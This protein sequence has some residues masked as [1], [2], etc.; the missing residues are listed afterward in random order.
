M[1]NFPF[2]QNRNLRIAGMLVLV[3]VVALADW[4]VHAEVPL[5]LLYLLPVA[6][7]GA[8]LS[9]PPI[10]VLALVCTALAEWFDGFIWIPQTALPRDVV[11]FCA[12]AGIGLFVHEV[13]TNRRRGVLHLAV[14][15][16]EIGARREV[17]EQFDILIGSSPIAILTADA[18]GHVLLA[19]DA[20]DRLFGVPSRCL[21]GQRIDAY[22]PAL[23]KV[24]AFRDGQP[25]FRTVMQCPG[26]RLDGEVFIAEVW[27]STYLTSVGA[28]LAAM[29]VDT[30][31]D[32][33]DREEANLH[34]L[35]TGSRILVSAVSHEVR[36]V[37][38]AIGVVHQNLAR[39]AALHGNKDFD[40]LGTL[41]LALE[42][43][44][45]IDLRDAVQRPTPLDLHSFFDE[46]QVIVGPTLRELGIE[47]SW[48][49]EGSLP[50]VW[51]DRQSLM[52]V[53]LNL[54]RNSQAA[55]LGQPQRRL[56]I[57]A[58]AAGN[59][60]VRI[61]L[62]D[63]G[64]GIAHP[65]LLFRPFQQRSHHVGLGLYLSR[66][67]MRSFKGDLRYQPTPRGATFLVE[68]ARVT[69]GQPA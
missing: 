47:A 14:L 39:T 65:D 40:A 69:E 60:V 50:T 7:A 30:S 37:C 22:L 57:D 49:L 27:F 13:L 24:P 2:H 23:L 33:R 34:H 59:D 38:G 9:R 58:A 15:E 25:S 1:V 35:L 51:A 54:I 28:R 46:L 16:K 10:L 53:F 12:F 64:P 68:L 67:L 48:D 17:E 3:L 26:R 32:L 62:I 44:A 43:V 29:I 55:L 56:T 45:S 8:L 4:R 63:T 42:R 5:A 31:Q 11:Y 41:V 66:A 6:F 18:E 20:A 36:N 19:N 21:P 61:S 52:Q